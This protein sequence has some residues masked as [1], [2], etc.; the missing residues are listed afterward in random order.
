PVGTGRP[1]TPPCVAASRRPGGDTGHLDPRR[2]PAAAAG[3]GLP[4][5][6]RSPLG[7]WPPLQQ[8]AAG[9]APRQRCRAASDRRATGR[10]VPALRAMYRPRRAAQW[11]L[12]LLLV[13]AT[14]TSV[15]A[16]DEVVIYR[17]TAA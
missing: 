4:A 6:A 10:G 17:C 16:Q 13:C 5:A 11:C 1:L 2:V 14:A 7:A 9:R 8:R 12:A 15:A 3:G